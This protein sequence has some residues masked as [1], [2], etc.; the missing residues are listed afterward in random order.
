[1]I[2]GV[3]RDSVAC[4]LLIYSQHI[5]ISHI[6]K[7]LLM[8]RNI[9]FWTRRGGLATFVA[10]LLLAG[11]SFA[12]HAEILRLQGPDGKYL[13][14]EH[15]RGDT[16]RPALLVLHGFLQTHEFQTTQ[17]LISNLSMLGYTVLGPNLSLGIS[18]RRQ[19]MQCQAPHKHIFDDDLREI[20]FWVQWLRKQGHRD[21]ILVG[22][23]WGSQHG[24]GYVEAHPEAPVSAVIAISL[25]R[26]EQGTAVRAKQ[27][28]VAQARAARHDKSLKPYALSFC[29]VFMAAPESYLSYARWDDAR[30]FDS[31]TRLQQR[32][33][34]V[35]A[36]VGN[37]DNRVDDEWIRELGRHVAQ[38]S[39][40]EGANHFF[41]SVHEFDLI[42][43]LETL[44]TRISKPTGGE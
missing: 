37:K 21:V 13:T 40:I 18:D 14:A 24:L 12:A 33:V 32:K 15:E 38:L 9:F 22:H 31:L 1:V 36:I 17:S 11:A 6:F 3:A 16:K 20:D 41:S 26:V 35:Y 2:S 23:S 44:L 30:V 29:K 42:E 27:I 8:N 25:V 28:S 34:P 39:V 5:E 10:I 4:I 19:S 7:R 43:R